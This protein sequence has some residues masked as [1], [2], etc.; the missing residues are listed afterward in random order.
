[1]VNG[2]ASIPYNMPDLSQTD[3]VRDIV[4]R[5]NLCIVCDPDNP[6]R[7]TIE[8]W[9]DYLDAGTHKDWTQKL[10]LSQSREITSTDTLKKQFS[11]HYSRCGG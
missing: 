8:P 3:F 7:L 9:Q 5:F 2:Y 11:L 6:M 1:L 10:D 4:E